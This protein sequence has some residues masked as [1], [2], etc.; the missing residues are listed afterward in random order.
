[1]AVA[2]YFAFH[3]LFNHENT[4]SFVKQYLQLYQTELDTTETIHEFS[5]MKVMSL[6]P[7]GG[8]DNRISNFFVDLTTPGLG[9]T[10]FTTSFFT[11]D[12]SFD[13]SFGVK[14]LPHEPEGIPPWL[15]NLRF[16]TKPNWWED[17]CC[18]NLAKISTYSFLLRTQQTLFSLLNFM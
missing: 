5:Y 12:L 14:G 6:F 3:K 8:L 11:M 2:S 17:A 16:S 13:I 9:V 18:I 15:Q 1:M 4:R 7:S 10:E